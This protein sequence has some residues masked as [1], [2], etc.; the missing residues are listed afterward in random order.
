MKL[1][2]PNLR[3][4]LSALLSLLVILLILVGYRQDPRFG[5][6]L[7]VT[8]MLGVWLGWAVRQ[9]WIY[10]PRLARAEARWAAGAPPAEVVAILAG[11]PLATGELGY[12]IRLLRGTAHLA[13]GERDRAWLD[14]LEAQLLRLPWWK[15][16]LISPTFRKVPGLPSA[17]RLAWGR[18]MIRLAPRMGRLRHLQGILLLRSPLA[19]ALH[20]AWT[21]FEEVLP[22]SADDPLI[23]E[24]LLLAGLQHGKEDVA[25]QALAVL[26]TRHGDVRLPWDRGAAGLFLLR[27]QRYV[28]ALALVQG[29]PVER[30]DQALLWL[31]ESVSRRQLGNLEGA[32]QVIETAISRLPGSFRLWLERYQIALERHEHEEALQS[33]DRAWPTIPEAEEGESLRQEWLLRRAEYALWWED[34]PAQARELLESVPRENQGD[35]HPPLHLQI[36]VAE[37]DYEPAYAEVVSLLKAQP[38][39]PDLLL[40]QADCLA[41]MQAW[42]ALLPYLDGLGEACRERPTYWHLRGLSRANL[43]DHLPARLDLERAVRM[44]PQGLRYLLDAGHASAELGDWDRAEGHWRQALHLDAE[45]EEALIHLAEARRELEDLEGARRY[46]RECLLHHPDSEDAQSRLAELEA[47]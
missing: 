33:L 27:Q 39:D 6:T 21:P 42:E 12:R 25:E 26:M 2:L 13:L 14:G 29:L 47:N 4:L 19:E 20:E 30:R 16:L 11:A 10:P 8:L 46:L 37:G 44:D 28:E 43:G 41:G 15:R 40:L 23:L 3:L 22:L 5:W 17:R 34:Q 7:P 18:S 38:G 45:C 31:T 35:H 9:G 24:D 32:W 36:Q 1:P